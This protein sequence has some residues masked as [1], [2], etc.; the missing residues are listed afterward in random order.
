M[1]VAFPVELN[2]FAATP[3]LK[4]DVELLPLTL[5]K[6]AKLDVA[7]EVAVIKP[8]VGD[9]LASALLLN[10]VQSAGER[11]PRAA[12]E[13]VGNWK[14]WVE[15]EETMAK[16]VPADEVAKVCEALVKPLS[17]VMRF[18]NAVFQSVEDATS[19]M[20]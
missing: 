20:T 7:V 15:F 6:P 14:V 4:V 1:E 5:M 17:E 19:G 3:P 11:R 18:K 10:V 12:A 16:S 8:N 9:E 2:A 13:A